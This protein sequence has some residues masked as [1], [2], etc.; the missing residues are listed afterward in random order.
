MNRVDVRAAVARPQTTIR[1]AR[2]DR[3]IGDLVPVLTV[4]A[5]VLIAMATAPHTTDALIHPMALTND[6]STGTKPSDGVPT[7]VEVPDLRG[8][9]FDLAHETAVRAGLDVVPLVN[10]VPTSDLRQA[11]HVVA[12]DPSPLTVVDRGT[13][14]QLSLG[15]LRPEGPYTTG[16]AG[17]RPAAGGPVKAYLFLDNGSPPSM[18]AHVDRARGTVAGASRIRLG[19]DVQIL[20][21]WAAAGQT[22]YL[23][24]DRTAALRGWVS[25]NDAFPIAT[26]TGCALPLPAQPGVDPT[27]IA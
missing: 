22:S 8:M 9:T 20:C 10:N 3:W 19:D 11:D 25:A 4:A 2:R 18:Y 23:V 26:P 12:Q 7:R 15:V 6:A 16:A 21:M 5:T 13:A 27:P 17:L 24:S 1:R 14:V